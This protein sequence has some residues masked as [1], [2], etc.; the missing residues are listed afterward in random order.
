M[1]QNQRERQLPKIYILEEFESEELSNFKTNYKMKV[2]INP[3]EMNLKLNM[4]NNQN[5]FIYSV[6][7]L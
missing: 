4:K 6:L 2:I 1:K 3:M 5:I 7:T